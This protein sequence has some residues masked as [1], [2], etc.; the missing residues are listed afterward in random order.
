MW[1]RSK[2]NLKQLNWITSES[3]LKLNA[4]LTFV[5]SQHHQLHNNEK[6]AFDISLDK[7]E[8]GEFDLLGH[9]LAQM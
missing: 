9:T 1:L 8:Y 6:L 5:S 2:T 4:E 7:G 3:S